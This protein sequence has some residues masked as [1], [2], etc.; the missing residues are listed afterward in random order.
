MTRCKP[1]D[2]L[3]KY[4]VKLSDKNDRVPVNKERPDISYAVGVVSQFMQAL[5]EDHMTAVERI[6]RHL[7]GTPSK[8]LMFRKTDKQSVE[9]YTDSD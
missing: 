4:N 8:G 2:T 5:Y 6:F 9:A 7:K 3:V 1:V